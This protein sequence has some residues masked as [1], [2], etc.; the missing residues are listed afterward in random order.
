MIASDAAEP[1]VQ[2]GGAASGPWVNGAFDVIGHR[3][4][5]VHGLLHL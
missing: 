5:G 3:R 1:H 2:C 4:A